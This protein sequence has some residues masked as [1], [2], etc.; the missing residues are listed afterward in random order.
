ME[1]QQPS[2]NWNAIS[3]ADE[4]NPFE[5][6]AW[7]MLIGQPADKSEKAQCEYLLIWVGEKGRDIFSTF[8]LEQTEANKVEPFLNIL[9]IMQAQRNTRPKKYT[10][11][12]RYMFQM[13][14]QLE[15]KSIER[16]VTELKTLAKQCLYIKQDQMIQDCIVCRIRNQAFQEKLLAEGGS[17]TLESAVSRCRTHKTTQAQ[18]KSFCKSKAMPIKQ[19]VDAIT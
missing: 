18:L 14:D 9:K 17:L 1:A 13:R 2:I 8:Q 7:L 4:W 16:Y 19:E 15:S 5:Q 10:V 3:L 12:A 6:H 11:L